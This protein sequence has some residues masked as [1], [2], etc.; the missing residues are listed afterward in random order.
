[1]KALTVT[2]NV[3]EAARDKMNIIEKYFVFSAAVFNS[4]AALNIHFSGWGYYRS[5]RISD[6][7][8]RDT[9]LNPSKLLPVI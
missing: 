2:H 6:L 3:L 7:K 1:M 9:Y 5:A 4:Q 8:S